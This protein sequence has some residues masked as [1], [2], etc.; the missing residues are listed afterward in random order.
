M[1][2]VVIVAVVIVAVVVPAGCSA[3]LEEHTRTNAHTHTLL[4]LCSRR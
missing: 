3:P 1:L 2:V 4:F